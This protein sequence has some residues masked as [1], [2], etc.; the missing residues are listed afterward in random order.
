MVNLG[1]KVEMSTEFSYELMIN[2]SHL[3]SF[4]HVNNATYLELYE[5]ARWDFIT[6]GNFGLERIQKDGIGPVILEINVKFKKELVNREKITIKTQY[7]G[8]KNKLIM[9]L[10]QQM[11]KIDSQIASEAVLAIG[12]FDLRER[13]LITPTTDWMNAITGNF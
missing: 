11:I 13:K 1:Q 3:D 10:T 8:M 9:E 6:A 4:G 2:E 5:E 7:G 12:L